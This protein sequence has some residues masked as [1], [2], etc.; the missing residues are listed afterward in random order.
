MKAVGLASLFGPKSKIYLFTHHK[1]ASTWLTR[2][3]QEY[4]R[5]NQRTLFSS[6]KGRALPNDLVDVSVLTNASY[7]FI[8]DRIAGGVHVIRNPMDLVVSAYY[9]HRQTHSLEGWPELSMQRALLRSLDDE[10]GMMAT[11]AFLERADFHRDAAGPLYA[12][13]HWNL[14]DERF[15]TIRME[16]VVQ[17]PDQLGRE[18]QAALGGVIPPAEAFSFREFSGR[19]PGD[20]DNGSHYRSGVPDRW[21]RDLPRPAVA[22]LRANFRPILERFYPESLSD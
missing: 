16:D 7:D 15:R 2:Y 4:C 6:H 13:R 11:I 9:S 21:R 22:Y 5:L 18:I 20:I 19:D 1:F 3:V 14:D 17:E 8:Q 10:F 12:L